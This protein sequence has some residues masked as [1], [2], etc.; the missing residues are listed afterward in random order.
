MNFLNEQVFRQ[1]L[2]N[3]GMAS[4]QFQNTQFMKIT[5]APKPS[6]FGLKLDCFRELMG[7][8]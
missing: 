6:C 3:L 7:L 8:A 1:K 2:R 5:R 4:E